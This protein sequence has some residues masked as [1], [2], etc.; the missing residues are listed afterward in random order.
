MQDFSHVKGLIIDMDGVLW[1]GQAFLPGVKA[2]F[3]VLRRKAIPFILVT[4]NATKTPAMVQERLAQAGVEVDEPEVLTS[5]QAAVAYLRSRFEPGTA[6]LPIGEEG[7]QQALLS[8]GFRLVERAEE[9]QAVVVG[10]D[11]QLTYGKLAE[12]ALAVG[13]GA[14]FVGTNPD[15]SFPTERGLVPGNGAI[16]AALERTTGIAPTVVGKPE[17]FLFRTAMERLGAPPESTVVLGDR[18]D[19]DITGGHKAGLRTA[20][21]LTGVTSREALTETQIQPN[22]VFEDLLH[23]I[24]AL[25]GGT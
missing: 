21:V 9:A 24:R 5:A 14:P 22:W 2:F 6:V 20:L 12:A 4:N 23:V 7:L 15:P 17:P 19:T 18:L 8:A 3:Q 1:R 11:R 25:T 13:A 16:L 10:M